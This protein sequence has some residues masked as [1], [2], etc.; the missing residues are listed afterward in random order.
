MS[1]NLG[2]RKCAFCGKRFFL[3]DSHLRHLLSVHDNEIRMV[4]FRRLEVAL[5]DIVLRKDGAS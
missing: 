2:N 4:P 1:L 3:I 5:L